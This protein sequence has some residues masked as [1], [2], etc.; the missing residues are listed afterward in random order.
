MPGQRDL[1][2]SEAQQ[3]L[4]K[5]NAAKQSQNFHGLREAICHLNELQTPDQV[6][7]A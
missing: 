5:A 1:N 2:Q 6:E 4:S 3:W 7:M